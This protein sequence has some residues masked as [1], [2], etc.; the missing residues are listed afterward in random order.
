MRKKNKKVLIKCAILF[1]S[2]FLF[3]G[4]SAVQIVPDRID[5]KEWS[6]DGNEQNAGIKDYNKDLGWHITENAA[7][8]YV[9]LTERY[10]KYEIPPLSKGEGIIIIPPNQYYLPNQYM[11]KFATLNQKHKERWR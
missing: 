8:R 4:C 5:N 7:K 10:G 2:S 3:L 9:S 11:V 6:F 1:L